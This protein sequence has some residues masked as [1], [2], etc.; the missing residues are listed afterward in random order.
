MKPGE[1]KGSIEACF[2]KALEV[3][4]MGKFVQLSV[5]FN[6]LSK[7]HPMIDYPSLSALLHF[8]K[9]C[10]YP[11]SHWLVNNGWEWAS[12]LA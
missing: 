5:V 10:N 9:V 1:V 12:C 6:I 2:G 7:G 3:E 8:L 11:N 4:L